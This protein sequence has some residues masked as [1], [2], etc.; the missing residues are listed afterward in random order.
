MATYFTRW[1][2]EFKDNHVASPATW[3]VDLLDSEGN[4]PTE[5]YKLIADAEPLVT[6]RV[7]TSEDKFSYIIGKQITVSY[8]YTG[9][10]EEPLP[11]LFFEATERRFRANVY[12][13][14]VL[15][16]VYYIKPDYSQYPDIYPPFTVSLSAVDGL[17][18]L[19][20]IKFNAFQES[21]LLLYD[22]ITL[23]DAM[24]TRGLNQ[25]FDEGTAINVI[26]TLVPNGADPGFH[27]LFDVSVHTDIFYDF[28]EGPVTVHD[29]LTAF[30][31]AFKARIVTDENQIW[32]IRMQ[33]MNY[34]PYFA[35]RYTDSDTVATVSLPGFLRSVGPSLSADAIPI[36]LSGLI[37][38]IPAV[39]EA[40][41]QVNYKGINRLLN[42]EWATFDGEDFQDWI[43]QPIEGSQLTVSRTGAGSINDPYKLFIPYPQAANDI[44]QESEIGIVQTGDIFD[45]ELRYRFANVR[46][47]RISIS[48]IINNTGGTAFRLLSDG[49][50]TFGNDLAGLLPIVRSGKKREGTFKIKSIPIPLQV[51]GMSGPLSGPF[52]LRVEIFQPTTPD[53]LEPLEPDGVEIWPIKLGVISLPSKGRHLRITNTSDFSLVREAES[54][55]F[56][57]TGEEG[58]S[59]TLFTGP[60][61][62]PEDGGWES[63]K[64]DVNPGDIE[65]LMAIS[66]IDQYQ[67]SVYSWEG[68][69]YSNALNFY[70]MLALSYRPGKIYMQMSD[71]YNNRTCEHA[72]L[73]MEV[74]EEGLTLPP[75]N[76]RYIYSEWDIEEEND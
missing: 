72:I 3:R 2:I 21:G 6:E 35:D 69:L 65:R 74:F 10:A 28:V 56:I 67:R 59:N 38:M 58:V 46:Q 41:F 71:K 31:K 34:A 63:P 70:N 61:L 40:N 17:S 8:K 15:D 54:F 55:S 30:C 16:G 76:E 33:D 73:M 45:L 20:G 75:P 47:F 5:P 22:K 29:M 9:A 27:L 62:T 36:N 19:K 23:Y 53:E 52:G 11:E 1:Y 25:V 13:N 32:F 44:E 12:K 68:Q 66:V 50:W 48:V 26:N 39:K 42:F 14:G 60:G 51:P 18:Y 64:P 24:M 49:S 4:A 43:R 37:R 57:D 7:D